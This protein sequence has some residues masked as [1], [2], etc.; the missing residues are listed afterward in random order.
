MAVGL[1]WLGQAPARQGVQLPAARPMKLFILAGQSNMVGYGNATFL[2]PDLRQPI[3]NVYLYAAGGWSA[4]GPYPA[5][6]PQFGIDAYAFGP[7]LTF[8]RVMA[9][10]YPGHVI[11]LVKVARGGT[12]MLAWSKDFDP[13]Q[14]ARENDRSPGPMYQALIGALDQAAAERPVEVAGLIWMQGEA[15][16]LNAEAAAA[17][18]QRLERFLADVRDHLNQ[19]NL[20]VVLALTNANHP[21][22]QT[23]RQAKRALAAADPHVALI[24]TVGLTRHADQLHYDT[25]GQIELGRRFGQGYLEQIGDAAQ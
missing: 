20:P 11:G 1:T 13:A 21:H 5:R 17:Y 12:S 6:R 10:A 25:A 23:V 15:D 24:D 8:G 14:A 3:P 19:P 16:A 2:P 7:E 22:T 4:L 18:R 9:D